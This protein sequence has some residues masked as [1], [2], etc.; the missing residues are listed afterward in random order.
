MHGPVAVEGA[1][2][3]DL[4]QVEVLRLDLDSFG[5]TAVIPGFGIL[6]AAEPPLDAVNG[7]ALV[8]VG[9]H[10][11]KR[12]LPLVSAPADARHT[13]P[14]RPHCRPADVPPWYSRWIHVFGVRVPFSPHVRRCR[15]ST[16]TH[17]P[18][19]APQVG[20]MGV[21]PPAK[22]GRLGC[23]PP[24]EHGGNLDTRHLTEG[25]V[26]LFPVHVPGAHFSLG[27][28]HAAQGDGEVGGTGLEV[29]ARVTVRLTL[30]K[31]GSTPLASSLTEW[32]LVTP[33]VALPR[34]GAGLLQAPRDG[35]RLVTTGF[36]PDLLTASRKAIT[37][38]MAVLKAHRPELTTEEAYMICS[39]AA[40]LRI[41]QAVD[42]PHYSV[43]AHLPL[44]V[45]H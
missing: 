9:A 36:A 13:H 38:M 43:A 32:A 5:W 8:V 1:E 16:P 40:D 26:A 27:D 24:D 29:G 30:L 3:G 42:L 25:A 33:A 15:G 35:A 45:L 39:M 7:P 34:L 21:A 10:A 31:K 37:A 28:V 14:P 23:M 20:S 6:S 12:G 4:L 22:R 44:A 2:P 18:H 11:V 19:A 17:T 41:S